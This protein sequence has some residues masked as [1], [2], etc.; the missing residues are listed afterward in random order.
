MPRSREVASVNFI[1][2]HSAREVK[3]SVSLVYP[4][5]H[6]TAEPPGEPEA[7][8]DKVGVDDDLGGG[9]LER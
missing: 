5:D 3:N 7:D 2:V 1:S 6:A 9:E 8:S 4:L